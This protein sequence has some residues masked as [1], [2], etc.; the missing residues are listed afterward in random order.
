MKAFDFSLA[1]THLS[2]GDTEF[3]WGNPHSTGLWSGTINNSAGFLT[4]RNL[5]FALQDANC[6]FGTVGCQFTFANAATFNVA[7]GVPEPGTWVTMLLGFLAVG[8]ALRNKP[9]A[10][11]ARLQL[12]KI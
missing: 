1:P 7:G 4:G 10:R 6:R 11:P 8:T 5:S 12:A 2:E 9:N 3:S